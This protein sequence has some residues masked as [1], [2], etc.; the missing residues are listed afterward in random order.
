M[1]DYSL[2]IELMVLAFAWIQLVDGCMIRYNDKDIALIPV[3][4]A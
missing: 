3:L 1:H 4:Y 2:R